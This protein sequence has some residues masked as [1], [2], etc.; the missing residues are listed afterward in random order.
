[1]KDRFITIDFYQKPKLC[2]NPLHKID[3]FL[4]SDKYN[5][6]AST[7]CYANVKSQIDEDIYEKIVDLVMHQDLNANRR[8]ELEKGSCLSNCMYL[9]LKDEMAKK[10]VEFKRSSKFFV[11]SAFAKVSLKTVH[12]TIVLFFQLLGTSHKNVVDLTNVSFLRCC[13]KS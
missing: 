11:Q 1:M 8:I 2:S 5:P 3:F 7:N 10:N 4:E 6:F 12:S 9:F 13:V